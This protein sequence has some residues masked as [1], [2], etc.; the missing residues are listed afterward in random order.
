M[1][2][3]GGVKYI[4]F[5][6]TAFVSTTCVRLKQGSAKYSVEQFEFIKEELQSRNAMSTR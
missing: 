4:P 1:V 5:W 3:V 2:G 6:R